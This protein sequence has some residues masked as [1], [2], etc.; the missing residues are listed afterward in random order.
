[1]KLLFDTQLLE[2]VTV[3]AQQLDMGTAGPHMGP[4]KDSPHQQG[5]RLGDQALEQHL[6]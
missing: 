6:V 4:E 3:M 5:P 2:K 1:M